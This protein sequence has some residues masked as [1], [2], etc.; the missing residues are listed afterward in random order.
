MITISVIV[1]ST[2]QGKSFEKPAQWI[3]QRLQKEEVIDAR[4][5]DPRDFPMPSSIRPCRRRSW[6]SILRE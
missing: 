4:L 5:L 1:G 3:L 2:R 6:A